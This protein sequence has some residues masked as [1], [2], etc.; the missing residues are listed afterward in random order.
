MSATR[1][2]VEGEAWRDNDDDESSPRCA[3]SLGRN[4][5]VR[6]IFLP[7]GAEIQGDLSCDL[8][9]LSKCFCVDVGAF[10]AFWWP[11]LL[12]FCV[13]SFLKSSSLFG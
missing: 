8:L 7:V 3:S 6:R 1:T 12:L 10:V 4:W 13:E 2:P 11:D 9:N 5:K